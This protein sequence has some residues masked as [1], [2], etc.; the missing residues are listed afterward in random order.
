MLGIDTAL[1]AQDSAVK[2]DEK[3]RNMAAE[4]GC[5]M[6]G[7]VAAKALGDRRPIGEVFEI[8]A[9]IHGFEQHQPLGQP[10][11]ILKPD[12]RDRHTSIDLVALADVLK[13]LEERVADLDRRGR[14]D[15][16]RRARPGLVEQAAHRIR[17]IGRKA[18]RDKFYDVARIL[19]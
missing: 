6:P 4:L 15:H 18:F 9:A 14:P 13:L 16:L 3:T 17:A 7:H 2:T 5:P 12:G 19:K 10:A 1:F 11:E 8:A